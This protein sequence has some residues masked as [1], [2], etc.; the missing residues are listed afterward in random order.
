MQS[1]TNRRTLLLTA[2]G[3]SLMNSVNKRGPSTDPCGT[4]DFYLDFIGFNSIQYNGLRPVRQETL[5]Q[6]VQF[7]PNSIMLKLMN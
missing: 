7:T 6:I 4:P 2:H 1:S 5:N 3:R